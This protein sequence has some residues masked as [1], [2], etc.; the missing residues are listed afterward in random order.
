MAIRFH[1]LGAWLF[2]AAALSTAPVAGAAGTSASASLTGF[3]WKLIDLNPDDAI[4]PSIT[5][6]QN[7]VAWSQRSNGHVPSVDWKQG[8]TTTEVINQTGSAHTRMD[9]N[10][11]F[12][13]AEASNLTSTFHGWS[14][15]NITFELSA[16][17]AIEFSGL[18]E[19]DS[20]EAGSTRTNGRVLFD[21]NLYGLSGAMASGPGTRL[22]S[23]SYALDSSRRTGTQWLSGR[24]QSGETA[25]YGNFNSMAVAEVNVTPVPEPATWSMLAAGVGLIGWRSRRRATRAPA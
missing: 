17:T 16:F 5:L 22:S 7:P 1:R 19:V 15:E 11:A 24:L 6:T 10:G 23:F 8:Y 4:A 18:A 12:A 21:G 2:A 25:A 3:S 14:T 9:G 13:W 20:S